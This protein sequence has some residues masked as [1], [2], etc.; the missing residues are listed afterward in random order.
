MLRPVSC[1][2]V[3][4]AVM[5]IHPFYVFSTN[6]PVVFLDSISCVALTISLNG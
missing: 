6:F 5:F 1:D 2:K 3:R 4:Y